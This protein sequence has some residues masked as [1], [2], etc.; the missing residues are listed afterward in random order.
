[1]R[2]WEV[3][4]GRQARQ[5][6]GMEF[7]LVEGLP[8]EHTPD[9]QIITTSGNTLRIYECVKKQQH[10]EDGAVEAPMACFK[11]PQHIISVRCVG[12]TICVGCY[13]GAVCLLS[14][15]LLAA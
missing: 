7:A 3:A 12:A 6:A 14:A 5:L 2:W 13:D 8:G 15:P 4:S 9:R 10:A 1:M 11:A